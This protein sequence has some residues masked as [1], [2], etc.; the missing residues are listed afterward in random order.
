MSIDPAFVPLLL[1][2]A[3]VTLFSRTIGF[4]A[5]RFVPDSRRVEA[6]L[7]ATPPAV[8]IGIVAPAGARGSVP[9]LLALAVTLT[10]MR[11]TGND[12]LSAVGGVAVVAGLRAVM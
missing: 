8:M 9:E 2:M 3:V 11:L 4:F 10:A 5:M 1:A 7:K 12:L 6:A